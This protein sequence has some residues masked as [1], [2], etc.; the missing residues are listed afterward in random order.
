MNYT[1]NYRGVKIDVQAVNLE[2]S[3]AVQQEIRSSIDKL[4][5][6]TS[7]INWLDIY[8]KSEGANSHIHKLGMKV[9]VPGPDVFAEDDGEHFIPMLKNVVEKLVRQLQKK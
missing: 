2:I 3:D 9:G 6:F 5:K 4:L 1:E 8:F 7:E